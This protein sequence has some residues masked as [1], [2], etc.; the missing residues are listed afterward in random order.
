MMNHNLIGGNIN[1]RIGDIIEYLS[2]YLLFYS[3]TDTDENNKKPP[4]YYVFDVRE[5]NRSEIKNWLI[6]FEVAQRINLEQINFF[7]NTFAY[8]IG[9]KNKNPWEF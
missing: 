6:N 7:G 4:T 9:K 2:G 5:M 1:I 3:Y 8:K